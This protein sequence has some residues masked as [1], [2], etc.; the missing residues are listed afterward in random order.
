MMNTKLEHI[1]AT[2]NSKEILLF[3]TL[4][5]TPLMGGNKKHHHF[6]NVFLKKKKSG[7]LPI[8]ERLL[9]SDLCKMLEKFIVIQST[10][11]DTLKSQ[12][13]LTQH[14]AQHEDT[15]LFND[16]VT[17]WEKTLQ[18]NIKNS[19]FYLY[20]S[21]LEYE[22]WKF[23]QLK[24]RF[25]NVEADSIILHSEIAQIS[26][27]L[28]EAVS[29][30]PQAVLI[31][32][33][34][35][36]E[37][38]DF[39]EKYIL[40][41]DYLQYPCISL[42][43]YALKMIF[44][45]QIPEWFEKFKDGLHAA[46]SF[47]NSDELRTLYF[48]AINYCIRKHNSGDKSYSRLLLDYY[49]SALKNGFLLTHGFLS[50]NSYRNINTIA[51]RLGQYD[52]A[53]DISESYKSF[54]RKEEQESAY[55]YNMANIHYATQKYDE[56]LTA[57]R[58][59]DFDDHLSNLTSKLLML[60][61]YYETHEIRLLDSHLDAMQVYLTRKKIIGY[62]KTVFSNIVKFTR[63]LIHLNPYDSHEKSKLRETIVAEKSVADKDWILAQID[64]VK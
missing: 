5:E 17:H 6:F 19:D 4:I 58:E 54:L 11:N 2:L 18:K 21:E 49:K 60:K 48:Q 12:S 13:I 31:S 29:L 25:S 34:I 39:L 53:I 51:I 7:S 10:L 52:E 47:F 56:A 35:N 38:I 59:V 1:I 63:K 23:E 24:S 15:K 57:L 37:Y 20:L 64:S 36:T 33:K 43:Y 3:C 30:A 61:I 50:K 27:K 40:K 32:K 9:M 28:A 8:N 26:K 62:H 42:Y 46:H 22:K 16:S 41:K 55:R 45:P 44:Y 14:Y